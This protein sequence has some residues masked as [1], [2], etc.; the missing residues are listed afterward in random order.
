MSS[1]VVKITLSFF[2]ATNALFF[3][4]YLIAKTFKLQP[5]NLLIKGALF[6][7]VSTSIF[8]T[9]FNT[10]FAIIGVL[11]IFG[12]F[13]Y[14]KKEASITPLNQSIKKEFVFTQIFGVISLLHFILLLFTW[15]L[16]YPKV[17]FRDYYFWAELSDFLLESGVESKS[18]F[19]T[20][21]IVVKHA[22]PYHYSDLWL[23]GIF[24]KV[25][26]LPG[27]INLFGITYPIILTGVLVSFSYLLKSFLNKTWQVFVGIGLLLFYSGLFIQSDSSNILS[28]GIDFFHAKSLIHYHNFKLLPGY[29][30]V[31]FIISSI[32][33]K[34]YYELGFLSLILVLI[35][36]TFFFALLPLTLFSVIK[37]FGIEQRKGWVLLGSICFALFF[38]FL[39]YKSSFWNE[40]NTDSEISINSFTQFLRYAFDK[41]IQ[42]VVFHL[43]A[44]LIAFKFIFKLLKDWRKGLL[45]G[46]SFALPLSAYIL[47]YKEYNAWQIFTNPMHAI[48]NVSLVFFTLLSLNQIKSK[49]KNIA[50][51]GLFGFYMVT[52]L[53]TEKSV[54]QY[55]SED[56]LG[57]EYHEIV[58]NL[59]DLKNV[60]VVTEM[61]GPI[62]PAD[63][64][65]SSVGRTVYTNPNFG[66]IYNVGLKSD[67]TQSALIDYRIPFTNLKSDSLLGFMQEKEINYI[68]I[69]SELSEKEIGIFQNF[70]IVSKALNGERLLKF[71]AFSIS[72]L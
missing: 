56:L 6:A 9:C 69:D 42:V 3:I 54:D 13:I 5:Q 10:V 55:Q 25:N 34:R 16:D 7:V 2:L 53:M 18:F 27:I 66:K 45:I 44:I 29:V 46:L 68:F 12:F 22:Q 39:L 24:T 57:K 11:L 19:L 47:F 36:P 40:R 58:T 21:N 67:G 64:G 63:Y 15:K 30:G 17:Q 72:D 31:V 20:E 61:D 38:S 50:F 28:P 65:Y 37:T 33:K 14:N 71:D 23:N 4:G 35:Y 8:Y 62:T 52:F 70:P 51:I 59:K 41:T 1:Y 43:L 49:W 48:L 32:Y 26:G 60:L